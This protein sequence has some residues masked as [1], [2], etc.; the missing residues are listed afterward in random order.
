MIRFARSAVILAVLI[1]VCGQSAWG[2]QPPAHRVTHNG[3]FKQRPVW[4]PDG[5]VLAFSQHRG[6]KIGLVF[7]EGEPPRERPVA[8]TIPQYDACWSPDGKRIAYTRVGQT[9]GQG[10]LDVYLALS[11]GSEPVKFAGDEGKLSHEEFPAWSPDGKRIA[12]MSTYEGNQEIY[13]AD[14]DGRNRQRLTNDPALDSHPAWS[15]DSRRLAFA[16]NRWGDF[17]IA[18]VDADGQNLVRLTKSP[19]LDDYPVYS[20]DGTRLAFVSNRDGNSEIYVLTREDLSV[21]NVTE[22]PAIDSYPA[23]TPNGDLTFVSNRDDGFD[24]YTIERT[25]E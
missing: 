18:E 24:I 6:G 2:G 11:D 10:N 13:I 9:P 14:V 7:L 12:Y 3:H 20:P 5:K 16:T 17:E 15:P 23:W 22:S 4:S 1:G 19:R 25:A 8:A 21:V